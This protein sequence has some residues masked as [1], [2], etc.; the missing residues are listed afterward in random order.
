MIYLSNLSDLKMANLQVQLFR[1]KL[2]FQVSKDDSQ[3]LF[4]SSRTGSQ[5]PEHVCQYD[6][7]IDHYSF[8]PFIHQNVS[9]DGWDIDENGEASNGLEY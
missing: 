4:S 1:H 9:W 3:A 5:L 2:A 7:T 6:N 8:R